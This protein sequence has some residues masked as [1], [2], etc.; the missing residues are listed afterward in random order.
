MEEIKPVVR[1]P[2]SLNKVREG[3]GFSLGELKEANLTLHDAKRIGI[4]VDKRRRS[5]HEENVEALRKLVDALKAGKAGRE[6]GV[7]KEAVEE[8]PAKK[9]E[10][11]K[12]EKV[13]RVEVAEEGTPLTVLKGLGPKTAE[14]LKSAGVENLEQLVKSD[15][16]RLSEATGVSEKRLASWIEE[17]KELVKK[18]K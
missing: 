5:V 17:A 7:E 6:V 13:E 16:K 15:A 4:R 10:E 1:V 8:A 3:R 12:V 18:K 14:K 11:A 9:V 2:G